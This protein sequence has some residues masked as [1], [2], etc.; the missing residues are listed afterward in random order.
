MQMGGI[1]G[2]PGL[3]VHNAESETCRVLEWVS[4]QSQVGMLLMNGKVAE[5]TSFSRLSRNFPDGGYE[6]ERGE[7]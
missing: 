3:S 6:V 2:D 1:I 5:A 4:S 7:S